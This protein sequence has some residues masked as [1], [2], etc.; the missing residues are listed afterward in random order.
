MP[1]Y[2]RVLR[3]PATPLKI[4][5]YAF[6]PLRRCF[7]R[8]PNSRAAR[9]ACV[10]A[11][12]RSD[13]ACAASARGGAVPACHML[14]LLIHAATHFSPCRC[15]HADR[16]IIIAPC[17][18]CCCRHADAAAA[19]LPM[20]LRRHTQ[21][22]ADGECRQLL[23]LSMPPA[24]VFYTICFRRALPACQWRHATI[25]MPLTPLSRCL[26]LACCLMM[27]HASH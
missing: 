10:R 13:V 18:R 7:A 11:R 14:L 26:M 25:I 24:E 21:L 2:V 4:T 16:H 3:L 8:I 23:P 6:S 12:T 1:R 19:V 5:R 27:R 15:F 17:R 9:G 20:P 22:K